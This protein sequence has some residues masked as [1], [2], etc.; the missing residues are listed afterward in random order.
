MAIVLSRLDSTG[1]SKA[2]FSAQNRSFIVQNLHLLGGFDPKIEAK[3][4]SNQIYN[5]IEF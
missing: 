4:F 1:F 3:A 2:R 5:G